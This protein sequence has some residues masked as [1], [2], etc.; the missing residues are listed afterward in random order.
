MGFRDYL[1]H[2][3]AYLPYRLGRKP[4]KSV[5]QV[6]ADYELT[7][8]IEQKIIVAP[9]GEQ[10]AQLVDETVHTPA[11]QSRRGFQRYI[12]LV[13]PVALLLLILVVL[14]TGS[15]S[16][17]SERFVILV[18]PFSDGSDGATGRNVAQALVA[19]IEQEA[20]ATDHAEIDVEFIGQAPADAT[21]ALQLAQDEQADVL[22]W[23]RVTP[24]GLLDN[25]TLFPR[26]TYA[27]AGP[28]GPNAWVGYMGRFSMPHTYMLT[29]DQTPL[30]G[31]FILPPLLMALADYGQGRADAAYIT[32][33]NLRENYP[34]LHPALPQVVQGNAL[35]ARG[36]YDQAATAY[37]EVLG[38]PDGVT[39]AEYALLYNNLGAILLDAGDVAAAEVVLLEASQRLRERNQDLGSLRFNLGLLAQ[40]QD[41]PD[42]VATSLEPARNLLAGNSAVLLALAQAYCETGRL[43]EAEEM[44]AAAEEQIQYDA[45]Q[46]PAA[47]RPLLTQ[48]LQAGLHEQRGLLELSRLVHAQSRITWELEVGSPPL[49]NRLQLVQDELRNAVTRNEEVMRAWRS[50]I[51]AISATEAGT[52]LV[53]NGQAERVERNLDRLLYY[54]AL[55]QTEIGRSY[56]APQNLI[57]GLQAFF[58]GNGT[59]LDE[60]Q[61]MLATL[62]EDQPGTVPVLLAYARALRLEAGYD[63]TQVDRIYDEVI[64][65]APQRPE[66]YYGK[67][68]LREQGGDWAAARPFMEQALVRDEDFFPARLKLAEMAEEP[69]VALTYLKTLRDQRPEDPLIHIRI[70]ETLMRQGEV[71]EAELVYQRVLQLDAAHVDARF[72][73]ARAQKALN[74]PEAALQS[75]NTVLGY[76]PEDIDALLF[77]GTLLQDLGQPD[78]ADATYQQA[79]D[80]GITDVNTLIA[81]G[82]TLLEHGSPRITVDAFNQ[83][84]RRDEN[85]PWARKGLARAYLELGSLEDAA[86][87]AELALSLTNETGPELRELRVTLLMLLGK[88]ELGLNYPDRQQREASYARAADY[89]RQAFALDPTQVEALLGQGQVAASRGNWSDALGFFEA[90][91]DLPTGASDPQV[92]FWIAEARLRQNNFAPTM[93]QAIAEYRQ[94]LDLREDFPEAW[95]GMA[96]AQLALG[97]REAVRQSIQ[98]ALQLRPAYA[99]ALL[100]RGNLL[101]GENDLNGALSAYS[102]AIEANDTLAESYYRRAWLLSQRKN[103]DGAISDLRRAI[104]LQPNFAEAHYLLGHAHLAEGAMDAARDAFAAAV[105]A[106]G[107]V[108]PAARFYQGVAEGHLGQNAAATA[109]FEDVIAAEGAGDWAIQARVEL[110]RIAFDES[111]PS[112][113][114]FR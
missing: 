106:Q 41:Q 63:P 17:P 107:G 66:G 22:I 26:L 20:R 83:A 96:H 55:V 50:R 59:P 57:G 62:R 13:V 78:A 37:R 19:V 61:A 38:R 52:G 10:V 58:A 32:L 85:N 40:Q 71:A 2:L 64:Q 56:R 105:A 33:S 25:R 34:E 29:D 90:A 4:G 84:I 77:K 69:A 7:P 46:V 67:G 54:Q 8:V 92:H 74:Q 43:A 82:D 68:L 87:Q 65:R 80:V 30:N 104:R 94:A 23:G 70:A 79:L 98:N 51:A 28:Y 112:F 48:Y 93:E 111:Q 100:F 113:L 91:R 47:L 99:E 88:I 11:D 45:E 49:P 16:R 27:P 101:Q 5:R 103:Y 42:D 95:L 97:D 76:R 15:F 31:Q 81:V 110:E 108:Y 18:T 35:W 39:D 6:Q 9:S 73:L 86:R 75:I 44:L 109:S 3:L 24:G 14:I 60:A 53:A 12:W 114:W 36:A 72:G 89:Y 21:A 102:A 1:L